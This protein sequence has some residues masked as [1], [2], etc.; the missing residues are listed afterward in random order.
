VPFAC[1]AAIAALRS[2]KLLLLVLLALPLAIAVVMRVM[3]SRGAELNRCL[4]MAG[5]LQW[6]FGVLFVIGSIR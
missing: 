3:R 4:A 5:A 2:Q 6:A 1:V